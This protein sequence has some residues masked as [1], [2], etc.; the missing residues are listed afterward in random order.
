MNVH[1]SKGLEFDVVIVADIE[2]K[3][4]GNISKRTL[5]WSSPRRP[6]DPIPRIV[7]WIPAALHEPLVDMAALCD[8]TSGRLIE[9]SLA[10]LGRQN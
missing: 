4:V 8:E 7:R 10:G 9:E 5:A 6:T 3:L 2:G 1:Q